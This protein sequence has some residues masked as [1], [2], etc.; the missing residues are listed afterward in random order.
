MDMYL[1]GLPSMARDLSA[2]AWA[3]QL[4]I[5][6]SMLGL[7]GGQLV[8]G[9]DQRRARAPAA[10]ARRRGRL[11]GGLAAVRDG[12]HHLAAAALPRRPGRGRRGR[13]SSSRGRSCA[14]CTTGVAAARIFALLMLV[15]GLA[16]ILA[17]L[18]GGELLHV[19][20]WRGI[21]VVLAGDRRAAA[22]RGVGDAG[23]DARAGEPPRRRP[24]RDAAA[25]SAASCATG[26]SWATRS[27][28]GLAFGAMA[29]YICGSPFVLQDIH[30]VSPQV[31][32]VLFALQRGR[33]HGRQP[34]QPRARRPLR[35]AGDAQRR[36]VD[37]RGRRSRRARLRA[38]LDLGLAAP[39][40]EPLRAGLRASASCSPTRP[41][42]P[43]PTT[44]ARP[45]A[46]RPARP[47]AVRHRRAGRPAG[48]R[49]RART[50]RCRW[51]SWPR[52]C[53]SG[54]L[55][56]AASRLSGRA[57]PPTSRPSARVGA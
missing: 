24:R 23:R 30:G 27:R 47:H 9:P 29:T 1:P 26:R 41:R 12:A 14:T 38:W 48:R 37:E 5:T 49:R 43:S 46:R 7:A 44:R 56:S 11:R 50:P 2:P 4:T 21:F 36:R 8:A 18:V 32:S 51:R 16:P 10:A 31:F 34:G 19:T 33:D 57:P 42:S 25:S 35:P 22:A 40:A 52:R 54:S 13:A 45:A 15:N 55:V 39:A 17:P 53:R 20:D 6:T 3:A 28:L